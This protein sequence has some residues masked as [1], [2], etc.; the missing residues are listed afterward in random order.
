MLPIPKRPRSESP[1]RSSRRNIKTTIGE[2]TKTSSRHSSGDASETTFTFDFIPPF[3]TPPRNVIARVPKVASLAPTAGH[4]VIIPPKKQ[5]YLKN[6]VSYPGDHLKSCM[7]RNQILPET[8]NAARLWL[9]TFL[10]SDIDSKLGMWTTVD[11]PLNNKDKV[12]FVR[13]AVLRQHFAM[14]V[15]DIDRKYSYTD[16]IGERFS[17]G[18]GSGAKTVGTRD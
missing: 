6:M 7:V 4:D 13:P 14:D 10:L 11:D 5:F 9:T 8:H 2:A 17:Y 18:S 16:G 15:P 12:N 1:R 3:Q